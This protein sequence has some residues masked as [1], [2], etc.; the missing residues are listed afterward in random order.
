M[1]NGFRGP[2]G[3]HAVHS[4]NGFRGVQA[5]AVVMAVALLSL[6]LIVLSGCGNKNN[7]NKELI[8]NWYK[9]S[10]FDGVPRSDAVAFVI[11]GKGYVGTGYDGETRLKDFWEYDPQL[12]NW[13]RKADFP[14]A[15]R[16]G[17]VGFATSTKGYIG[18]GYD[19]SNRLKDFYEYDPATDT[20]RQIADFGGSA[21][22]GA[23][24]FAINDK[25]YV[26]TGD[27]ENYLKDFWQYDPAA[28]KWTQKVSLSGAKRRDG[29][30]FVIDGKAYVATGLNNGTYENDL[31]QYDPAN[32]KWT[33]KNAIAD[34]SSQDFDDDYTNI[35]GMG[36]VAFAI[37]GTG[38]IATGGQGTAGTT[39]WAYNPVSDRWTQKTSLEA[40][41]RIDAVGFGIGDHGYLATGRNASYY[42]DDLWGFTPGAAQKDLDKPTILEP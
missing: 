5:P 13:T 33:K 34:V 40:S 19:G 30:A 2:K 39:V 36:K 15:A 22:F 42:F 28:N 20:W 6:A 37:N 29:V 41:G 17:A 26:G 8:G 10:D 1:T 24:A 35:V 4:H 38:F 14:G 11:G 27:D 21:R 7:D 16:N 31:W 12:N 3:L 23:V 32:D 18:T 25:G 9:L